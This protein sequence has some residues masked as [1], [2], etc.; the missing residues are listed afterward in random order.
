MT[1]RTWLTILGGGV[2]ALLAGLVVVR[3]YNPGGFDAARWQAQRGSEARE[4][5]S[6]GP[7]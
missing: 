3:A 5:G 1:R 7:A 2:L 4:C 6:C